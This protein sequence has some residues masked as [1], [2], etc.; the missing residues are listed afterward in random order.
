MNRKKSIN[1]KSSIIILSIIIFLIALYIVNYYDS[2]KSD[3]TNEAIFESVP[4]TY[5][6]CM[7]TNEMHDFQKSRSRLSCSYTV[8]GEHSLVIDPA[9]KPVDNKKFK[10][11]EGKSSIVLTYAGDCTLLFY[12]PDYIFPKTYREC[13]DG[14]KGL[15]VESSCNINI[16]PDYSVNKDIANRL[17]ED[18]VKLGGDFYKY[19]F[20]FA[21]ATKCSMRFDDP[22]IFGSFCNVIEDCQRMECPE[23]EDPL[24]SYFPNCIN[25]KCN[26]DFVCQ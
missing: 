16:E 8:F 10:E 18:C 23:S 12:N 2:K 20:G 6:E 11:C 7:R 25:N 17:L 22:P 9:T 13:V 14:K 1:K 26:C 4:N 19:E 5:S 21:N 3:I 15:T 24:C